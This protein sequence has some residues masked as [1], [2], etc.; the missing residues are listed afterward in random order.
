MS[1]Q[2]PPRVML[3]ALFSAAFM[4]V[5]TAGPSRAQDTGRY[6]QT[7][8]EYGALL[9]SMHCIACHGENGDLLPQ[10]NL[11]SGRFPNSP[12]DS[13]LSDNI[14]NGIVGTAMVATA[15]TDSEIDALVAYVRNITS[16]ELGSIA[17]GDP[18]RGQTL[19]VG[20]GDCG[21]C[22]RV[23]GRGPRFAPDLSDI[24]AVRSAS[25]LERRLL[26]GEGAVIP[27]NRPV[28][29][30]TQDGTVINGRRINEDT[31][32]IQLVDDRERLVSLVKAE[33]REYTVLATSAMPA[34]TDLLSDE[35]RADLLAYMLSLKGL[36]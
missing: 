36:D 31:Y 19:F 2:R 35:E 5:V 24:G 7:D 29:I 34:Y 10:M 1:D 8:I 6:E 27:I 32:T 14:R 11:R 3:S 20:K 4:L 23:N 33:F 9:F 13:Q 15:Y 25:Q 28:R 12:G 26:G 22:H 21:S 18:I 17:L 30:V 16:V